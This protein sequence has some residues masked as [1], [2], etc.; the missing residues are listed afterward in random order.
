VDP[1]RF[2][3][4]HPGGVPG[5][6]WEDIRL[7]HFVQEIGDTLARLSGDVAELRRSWDDAPGHRYMEH[8]AEPMTAGLAEFANTIRDVD[9]ELGDI[10]RAFREEENANPP[11]QA[12]G[13]D[14]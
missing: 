3:S 6:A 8:Y 13:E 5:P 12:W 4:P 10:H 7:V 11:R 1:D 2:P 9:Q 14:E